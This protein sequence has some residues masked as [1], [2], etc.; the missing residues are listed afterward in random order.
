MAMAAA[1]DIQ[2]DMRASF[3]QRGGER[4]GAVVLRERSDA[5]G[6]VL[7]AGLG[8]VGLQRPPVHV[9]AVEAGDRRTR[10][11]GIAEF[12]EPESLRL[13][14]RSLGGD[15]RGDERPVRHRQIVQLRIRHLFGEI[16]YVQFHLELLL[17]AP[18]PKPRSFEDRLPCTEEW[19]T[20][21][22]ESRKSDLVQMD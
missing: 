2:N 13:T 5:R 18:A 10:F 4:P 17:F 1:V 15:D 6:A 14:A 16:S 9:A 8:F 3:R 11:I 7:F 20:K 19:K 12:D 22:D 21:R